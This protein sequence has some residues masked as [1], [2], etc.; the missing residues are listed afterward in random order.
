M[1]YSRKLLISKILI[2]VAT[3][4]YLT[5]PVL[6]N[7][8]GDIFGNL[9]AFPILMYAV[10]G[11]LHG[12]GRSVRLV[13]FLGMAY[14]VGYFISVVLRVNGTLPTYLPSVTLIFTLLTLGV[15]FS[16]KRDKKPE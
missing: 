15:L 16:I 11:K 10:W 8:N 14:A 5:L 6:T 2:T 1:D 4:V 7:Y 9:L 13:A 12:T 3:A